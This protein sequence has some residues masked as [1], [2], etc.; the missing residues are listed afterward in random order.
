MVVVTDVFTNLALTAARARGLDGMRMLVL[1]HPMESRST[2]EIRQI[3]ADRLDEISK[4][5]ARNS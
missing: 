1:P 3:A 2:T 4:L 5:L